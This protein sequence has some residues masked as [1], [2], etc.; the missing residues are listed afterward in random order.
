MAQQTERMQR[1]VDDLLALS[2]L[3]D[4]Q[5]KLNE[6]VIDMRALVESSLS[7]AR[8]LSNGKHQISSALDAA[9]LLCNRD[10][11]ASVVSNLVA[12]A[13]RYTP[14]GGNIHV[15]L[16]IRHDTEELVMMVKDNGE[17]IAPEHLPRLT[18]RFYR[19]DRGRSRAAGGTGLGLA[20][21]KHV[22]MRHGGKLEIESAQGTIDHGSTFRITLP[23]ARTM[24]KMPQPMAA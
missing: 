9:W 24:T 11:I 19:V 4:A 17:G 10:E 15:G 20:I 23:A 18:E 14:P 21:V 7:D 5:N 12:N 8:I 13:V 16:E 1:L 2:R 22:M 3:E 6:T